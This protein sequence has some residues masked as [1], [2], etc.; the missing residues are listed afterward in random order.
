M[1]SLWVM[2]KKHYTENGPYSGQGETRVEIGTIIADRPHRSVRALLA[3][4]APTEHTREKSQERFRPGFPEELRIRRAGSQR[5]RGQRFRDN[6][7]IAAI[8]S[9]SR[10]IE[11]GS[12]TGAAPEI[13]QVPGS[14]LFEAFMKVWQPWKV[15][16]ATE[17]SAK[18]CATPTAGTL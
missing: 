4:T 18:S 3:H 17:V 15:L 9:I 12:G 2:R 13:V 16:Q 6:N 7:P 1:I 14:L 5:P 11:D 10:V 8:P